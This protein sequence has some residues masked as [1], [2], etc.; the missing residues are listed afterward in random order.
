MTQL[1]YTHYSSAEN[2]IHRRTLALRSRM[3][4]VMLAFNSV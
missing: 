1:Q 4:I 3:Y 2:S